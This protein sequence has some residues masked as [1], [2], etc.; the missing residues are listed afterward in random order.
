MTWGPVEEDYYVVG[1]ALGE[2]VSVDEEASLLEED[3][4]VEVA[5]VQ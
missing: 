3:C 4:V 2:Y 5:L 1:A